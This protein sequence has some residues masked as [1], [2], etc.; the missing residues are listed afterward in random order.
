MDIFARC[1]AMR[2]QAFEKLRRPFPLN[3]VGHTS[4]CGLCCTCRGAE[5]DAA[6]K[7]IAQVID[8]NSHKLRVESKSGNETR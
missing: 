2:G 4:F 6:M 8:L 3:R 1:D 5:L 7:A